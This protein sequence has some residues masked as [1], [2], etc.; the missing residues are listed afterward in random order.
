LDND[1]IR[2]QA[3]KIIKSMSEVFVRG[4]KA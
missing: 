2:G 3:R 4:T 1:L